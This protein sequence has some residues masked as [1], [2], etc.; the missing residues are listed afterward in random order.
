MRNKPLLGAAVLLLCLLPVFPAQACLNDYHPNMEI[1]AQSEGLVRNLTEVH[2]HESWPNRL[3]RLRQEVDH[4]GDYQAQN[5]LASALMHMGFAEKAV[6]ILQEIEKTHPGLYRTA[7][8]LGT[9]YELAGDPVHA[10]EWIRQGIERNPASHEGTEWLHI[11]IL[12]TKIAHAKDPDWR[13]EGSILGLDF[14]ESDAL[15]PPAQM[16]KGN[17]GVPL[18]LPQLESALTYQLHERLQFVHA[19][20]PLVA[21]LLVD[22]GDAVALNHHNM[23]L[24]VSVYQLANTYAWPQNSSLNQRDRLSDLTHERRRAAEG[25]NQLPNSF[26]TSPSM[27]GVYLGLPVGAFGLIFVLRHRRRRLRAAAVSA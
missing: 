17:T 3:T 9:A 27:W 5:D 4:G 23:G 13:P 8:N 12:E 6:P 25:A 2:L 15:K 1:V 7:S 16:P 18:T 14:G 10:L 24:A 20:D 26:R 11:R 19:P 21:S 22:L